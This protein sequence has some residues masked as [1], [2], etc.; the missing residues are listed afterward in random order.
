VDYTRYLGLLVEVA[1]F[2]WTKSPRDLSNLPLG[3]C[4]LAM[5]YH[6]RN[7]LYDIGRETLMFDEPDPGV[8]DRDVV[9]EL[10]EALATDPDIEMPE[11]YKKVVEREI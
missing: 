11:G 4:V 6:F 2:I 10:N 3:F 9:R 5:I 1:V 8:G 7:F